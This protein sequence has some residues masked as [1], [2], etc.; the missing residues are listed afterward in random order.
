MLK[1]KLV[2]FDFDGTLGDTLPWF[3]SAFDLVGQ[4][5]GIRKLTPLD[6]ERLRECDTREMLKELKVPLWK[7]ALM[8][9]EM[10]KLMASRISETKLF[11]GTSGL[12]ESLSRSGVRLGIVSTNSYDNISNI[13]GPDNTALIRYFECGVSLFGKAAKLRKALRASRIPAGEALYVGDELRDL[14]AARAAGL[15]FGAVTWGYNSVSAFQKRAPEEIFPTMEQ[16]VQRLS[17][18]MRNMQPMS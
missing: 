5:Y 14:N 17:S 4:Q 9:A 18:E 15:A 16:M 13:L 8:A 7:V 10:R 3:Q 2:L 6:H 12:L 1:Y 11:P